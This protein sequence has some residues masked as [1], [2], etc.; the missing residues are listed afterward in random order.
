V[1][2]EVRTAEDAAKD[3]VWSGY[4]FVVLS[5]AKSS[6]GLKVIDLGAGHASTSETL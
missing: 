4:R 2:T 3:Q 1:Q 5:D 6:S